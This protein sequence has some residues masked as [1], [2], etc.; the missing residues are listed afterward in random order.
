MVYPDAQTINLL[1]S[2]SSRD[3]GDE[4]EK[5]YIITIINALYLRVNVQPVFSTKVFIV[6]TIVTSPPGDGI[7]ILHSHPSHAKL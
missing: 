3:P 7:V 2:T 4:V 6:D 1:L 5:F